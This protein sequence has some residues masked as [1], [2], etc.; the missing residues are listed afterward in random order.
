MHTLGISNESD[1]DLLQKTAD[2]GR[3]TFS[4]IEDYESGSVLN[5]KVLAALK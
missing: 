5:A 1:A 3:G 4:L 2:A